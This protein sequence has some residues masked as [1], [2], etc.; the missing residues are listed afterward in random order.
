FSPPKSAVWVNSLWFLSVLISLTCAMLATFVQKWAR[1]YIK[2]TQPSHYSPHKRARL[3]AFFSDGVDKW[4]VSWA[5]ETLPALL[6]ISHFLF[7]IGILIYLLTTNYTVFR[8]VVWWVVLSM[9]AYLTITLLPIFR[10]NSPYYAP[11][12]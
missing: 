6:H 11:L 2:I 4:H 12:S 1:R 8:N 9:V 10:P 3:R 7:L 5:I